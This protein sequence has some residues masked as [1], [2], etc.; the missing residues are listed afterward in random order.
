MFSYT[1]ENYIKAVY[2]LAGIDQVG[3]STNSIAS[4]LKTKA[5]SV[6]DMLQRLSDKEV[7]KYQKYK[8]AKLTVKGQKVALAIIRKHRLWEVFLVEKLNFKWDEVHD[9]AEQLEHIRS[10]ELTDRLD[11]FLN[12]P[13]HDPH[14]DPIPDANGVLP[15]QERAELGDF[16]EGELVVVK[17]VK[18]NSTPFLQY[19]EK[20]E[21]GIGVQ[22]KIIER[23][24]FDESIK[25]EIVDRAPFNISKRVS[26]NIYVNK[27]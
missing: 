18:D 10:S 25:I 3:A 4:H 21:I 22:L 20:M 16:D 19:L 1:E 5:S 14:G 17:G 26:S 9:M 15:Q 12:Y 24:E 6:T 13:T 27:I 7:V 23:F 2:G 8:G 11:A